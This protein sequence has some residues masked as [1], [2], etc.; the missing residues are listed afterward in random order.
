MANVFRWARKTKDRGR[1]KIHGMWQKVT[2]RDITPFLF[3]NDQ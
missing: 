3:C 1:D 2:E